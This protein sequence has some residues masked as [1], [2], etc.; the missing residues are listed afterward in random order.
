VKYW[1][2]F[3]AGF[4]IATPVCF[5][6]P[7]EI[8]A[9]GDSQ[10]N[11]RGLDRS[12]A[13]PAQ[14]EALLRADGYDVVVI[15]SGVD[16]EKAFQIYNRMV[17]EVNERTE[18]VIF[19][20]GGNDT[21][22]AGAVEYSEKAFAWLQARHIPSIFISSR[23][24]QSD[25]DAQRSTDKYGTLYYGRLMKDIPSDGQYTQAGEFFIGKNKT[26]Y[27]L[28][29]L[30]YGVMAKNMKPIVKEIIDTHHLGGAMMPN[31]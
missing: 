25:E 11:G 20:G 6:E 4:V 29:A 10:T 23:R 30:G 9:I 22:P 1:I 15:N 5:A 2:L 27:H 14:L 28:T 19:Q 17:R 21:S 7:V 12:S 24:V 3:I 13:Y 16:G 26:D 31:Q 8:L 18:I